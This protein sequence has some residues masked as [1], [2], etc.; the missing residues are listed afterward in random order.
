MFSAVLFDYFNTCTTAVV[1]GDGHRRTAEVLGVEPHAW[2]DL[3]DRT[4]DVRARG[5]YGG[6]LAGLR[7]LCGELGV[8]PTPAQLREAADLR[9]ATIQQDAPP[10][11][12]TEPVL[13]AL[14]ER[15]IRTAVVSDCWF[16]LP[17]VLPGTPIGRLFDAGVYSSQVGR[18]KPHPAM[19]RT[20][21]ERLGVHPEACLYIGDGGGN[22][23]TGARAF[24]L[25]AVQ[26]DAP[27]LGGHLTFHADLDWDGAR[28]TSLDQI[29]DLVAGRMPLPA[30]VGGPMLNW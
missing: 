18:A 30:T 6:V 15:G 2:L 9:I 16:E 19:Y 17:S 24:G 29:P 22:E 3:L 28:I 8:E 21:C 23:L 20:A 1:R 7:A 5:A 4:F 14:R 25:T 10:R 26:L 13:R 12:E 11:P 27:D